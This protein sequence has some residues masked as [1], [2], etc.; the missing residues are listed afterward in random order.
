MVVPL[1]FSRALFL[2]GKPITVQRGADVEEA[3]QHLDQAMNELAFRADNEFEQL[4][5]NNE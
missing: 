3:R 1:P 5:R 4:W 2:Y